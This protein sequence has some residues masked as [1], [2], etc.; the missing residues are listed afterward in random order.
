MPFAIVGGV[1][2]AAGAIGGAVVSSNASQSAA[3]T[4]ANADLSAQQIQANEFNTITGQE[5]PY[6]TG[7]NEAETSLQQL[8]GL[9]SGTSATG[10]LANGYLN[11]TF[12]PSQFLNSPQYQFQLQQGDL[13]NQNADTPGSGALSGAALKDLSQYNQ[14]LASTYYGNY[15]NMF[16]T[17][18]NNIYNRLSGL[19][20]LGQN[21]AGNLGNNGAQ[22]ATGE[23]QA[24]AAAGAAQA[25]GQVGSA[26][27]YSSALSGLGNTASQYYL[28]S[29]LSSNN[30]N[31]SFS[32]LTAG[33][34]TL[35]E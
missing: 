18:Q 8:L 33:Q 22:L 21:A 16:Q 17:Q 35:D 7:G 20:S 5:Q 11:Q 31:P 34:P 9:Q 15:F 12:D 1:I 23:A 3:Q 28:A 2:A 26:N 30:N 14:G 10:G 29:Q 32:Q 27:A 13:A 24:T 19:A 4:Q 25:A 6:L